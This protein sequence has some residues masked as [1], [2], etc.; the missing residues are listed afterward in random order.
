MSRSGDELDP[1]I[2]SRK[3]QLPFEDNIMFSPSKKNMPYG[4]AFRGL[5]ADFYLWKRTL[6]VDEMKN[7]TTD[8]THVPD[9]TDLI[10]DWNDLSQDKADGIVTV[11][12]VDT[13]QSRLGTG[14]ASVG[15]I[16]LEV[17]FEEAEASCI[18]MGGRLA[19]HDDADFADLMAK[20][21]PSGL[22]CSHQLWAPYH[23]VV[24]SNVWYNTNTKKS[25]P[26]GEASFYWQP[27][28]PNGGDLQTCL[29]MH[30]IDGKETIWDDSCVNT[31]CCFGCLFET[32]PKVS[33]RGDICSDTKIDRDYFLVTYKSA[34]FF[35]GFSGTILELGEDRNNWKVVNE[36]SEQVGHV[37][38]TDTTT[39]MGKGL[40][41]FND[42]STATNT[43]LIKMTQVRK[44]GKVSSIKYYS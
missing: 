1:L 43:S 12:T 23:K 44:V 20:A 34:I 17:P 42:C 25:F 7:Y 33:V 2:S 11:E 3:F 8:C 21:D 31:H 6:S 19:D 30:I 16:P 4:D 29:T 40:W 35:R 5:A 32:L 22:N 27:G 24:G 28:Q 26:G 41:K 37:T 39:P 9:K 36:R 18:R 13:C 15:I 38:G 14:E 10:V